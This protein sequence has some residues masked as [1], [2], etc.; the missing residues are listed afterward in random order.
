M[1]PSRRQVLTR[2]FPELS[3]HP[4]PLL[5]A[6]Y[7][8]SRD[9]QGR[10]PAW[11]FV[12]NALLG[13]FRR[14]YRFRDPPTRQALALTATSLVHSVKRLDEPTTPAE[15]RVYPLAQLSGAN[16]E[17]G[18]F[19][20]SIAL[21]FE[22]DSEQISLTLWSQIDLGDG[23]PGPSR[24]EHLAMHPELVR[25]SREIANAVAHVDVFLH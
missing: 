18:P 3:A 24:E 16:V 2:W 12:L 7:V 13:R 20:E 21:A 6:A 8:V 9:A 19:D 15:L 10:E 25:M 22:L 5:A 14:L 4:E 17:P 11:M 23:E 1:T